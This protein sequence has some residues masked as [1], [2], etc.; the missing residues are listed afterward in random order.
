[1]PKK[2][3]VTDAR[4]LA[5]KQVWEAPESDNPFETP[6][7]VLISEV[8]KNSAGV[9][10]VKYSRYL[11]NTGAQPFEYGAES[12]FRAAYPTFVQ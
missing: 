1:M 7:Q 4:D 12:D 8:K 2:V 9:L 10:W 6:A 11:P 3:V 5:A